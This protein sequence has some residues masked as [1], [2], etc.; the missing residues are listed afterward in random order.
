MRRVIALVA[1]G[2]IAVC[3]LAAQTKLS[4]W[5]GGDFAYYPAHLGGYGVENFAPIDYGT[6]T[7]EE[8]ESLPNSDIS[9]EGRDLGGQAV[10]MRATFGQELQF[11]F[12]RGNSMLTEGNNVKIRLK[13]EISP[14]TANLLIETIFTPV[15]FLSIDSVLSIGT[16]WAFD[17]SSGLSHNTR[18]ETFEPAPFEGAVTTAEAGAT[19]QF[20]FGRLVPGD[21]THVVTVYRAGLQYESFTAAGANEPWMWQAD[22]GENYNGWNWKQTGIL[23]YQMPALQH[24]DTAG[25]LIETEQRIT[26]RNVSTMED[27]GWG[28]DFMKVYVSFF[29]VIQLNPRHALTLQLQ[30]GRARDYTEETVGNA[31]FTYR[32]IDV[33][34][35]VY[36]YFRRAALSYRFEY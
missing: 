18:E 17:D 19:F 7:Q 12:L 6:V 27:G 14:V 31:H 10:E 33:D 25:V 35:P 28:S 16:G 23:G 34:S 3:A 30:C 24:I 1:C 13:E 26:K 22:N 15:A 11:P 5:V 4:R 20:D 2:L 21:W 36:W 9:D 32:K 29:I 8:L